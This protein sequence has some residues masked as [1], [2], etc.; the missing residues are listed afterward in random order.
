[1]TGIDELENLYYKQY[2]N[3]YNVFDIKF[4]LH[5]ITNQKIQEYLFILVL[6]DLC[7]NIFCG[8]TCQSNWN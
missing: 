4:P 3:I 6:Y 1:M 7:L 2:Q 8:C 5:N